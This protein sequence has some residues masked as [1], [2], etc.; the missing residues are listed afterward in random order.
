MPWLTVDEKKIKKMG[1]LLLTRQTVKELIVTLKLSE[2]TIYRYLRII[3]GRI[4][5]S[6]VK[7]GHNPTSYWIA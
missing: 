3:D 6:V 7:T 2:R 5:G 4:T 1:R